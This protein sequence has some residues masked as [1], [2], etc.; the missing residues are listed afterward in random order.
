MREARA[1]VVRAPGTGVVRQDLLYSGHHVPPLVPSPLLPP[2]PLIDGGRTSRDFD[3]HRMSFCGSLNVDSL[4]E[5]MT[6]GCR[7]EMDVVML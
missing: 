6:A 7:D 5:F 2:P 4:G 3:R 1:T